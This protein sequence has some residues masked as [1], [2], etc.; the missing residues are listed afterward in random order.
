MRAARK[1]RL[2]M[3][4]ARMSISSS[5]VARQQK[6]VQSLRTSSTNANT[7]NML[8]CIVIVFSICYTPVTIYRVWERA[9]NP[10][11]WKDDEQVELY[12]EHKFQLFI[13]LTIG[14]VTVTTNSSMNFII[15]CVM[16]RKFRT[17]LCRMF[18]LHVKRGRG[19]I[20]RAHV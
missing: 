9:V 16:G 3:T 17:L 2:K 10:T 7:T 14:R 4:T 6:Q 5:Q 1:I 8:I 19:Q 18:H 11:N 15:Y 13:L 12:N 20:G